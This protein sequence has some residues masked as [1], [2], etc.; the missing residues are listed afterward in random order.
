M[1]SVDASQVDA[2]TRRLEAASRRIQQEGAQFQ[3]EWGK[4]LVDE[5]RA[6]VPVQ[7]GTLRSS[8][9]QVDPG[10]ITFGPAFYWRFLEYGTS[11]MSPQ[12]FVRPAVNRIRK[13]AARDA[14]DRAAGLIARG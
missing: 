14:T 3:Q 10:D 2:F 1:V 4:A 7:T 9:D 13:P 8:I 6:T 11:K 12:P 5:M